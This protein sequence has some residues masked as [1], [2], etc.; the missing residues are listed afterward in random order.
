MDVLV[1]ESVVLGADVL[2]VVSLEAFSQLWVRDGVTP[3]GHSDVV[4]LF[5]EAGKLLFDQ[6]AVLVGKPAGSVQDASGNLG[7]LEKVN[8]VAFGCW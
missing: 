7:F 3:L 4:H 1:V 5:V 8:Q 6:A 2:L